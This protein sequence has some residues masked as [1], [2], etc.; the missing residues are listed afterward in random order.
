MKYSKYWN[1]QYLLFI[2]LT[3]SI[4]LESYHK[5]IIR[6]MQNVINLLGLWPTFLKNSQLS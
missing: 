2:T 6:Q 5:E 1:I 4:C 3:K